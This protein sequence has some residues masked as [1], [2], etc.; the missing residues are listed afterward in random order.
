M[1][2]LYVDQLNLWVSYTTLLLI[3]MIYSLVVLLVSF[4]LLDH[5]HVLL[6]LSDIGVVLLEAIYEVSVE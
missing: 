2:S 5:V 6:A 1:D 3:L 4:A